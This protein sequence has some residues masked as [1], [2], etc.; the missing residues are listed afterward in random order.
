MDWKYL[1][2]E[3]VNWLFFIDLQRAV[4]MYL[5]KSISITRSATM[6]PFVVAPI[7]EEEK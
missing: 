6:L 7:L 5:R 1:I 4:K 2:R 3:K